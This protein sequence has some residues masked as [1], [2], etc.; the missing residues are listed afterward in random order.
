MLAMKTLKSLLWKGKQ[1]SDEM[2][3]EF[4]SLP[5]LTVNELREKFGEVLAYATK[6]R[7][8]QFLMRK[9]TW[10]IQAREWGD[11][12]PA[13]RKRAHDL[14]DLRFLRVR[15]PR[16]PETEVPD[17]EGTY[18]VRKKVKLSRDPRIPMPGCIITKDWDGGRIEVRVTDDDFEYAGR[19]Y[20]SLSAIAREVT[21]TNWN[22]FLFF[23]LGGGK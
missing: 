22:G 15:M 13:A 1:L 5:T 4:D 7:N 19:Q 14:A 10:G 20:R 21:G 9:I 16:D 2:R 23:G 6:S 18:V 12:S 3:E 11:I 17:T 8:R